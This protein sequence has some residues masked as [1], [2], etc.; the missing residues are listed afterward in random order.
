MLVSSL[1]RYVQHCNSLR[2]ETVSG[3]LEQAAHEEEDVGP[4]HGVLSLSD[5][6][7]AQPGGDTQL[8]ARRKAECD[9]E[10]ERGRDRQTAPRRQ[11]KS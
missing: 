8:E 2:C 5:L 7:E 6:P 4:G 11:L 9:R 1:G 3:N 10:K